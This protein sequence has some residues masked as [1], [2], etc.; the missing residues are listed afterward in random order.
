MSNFHHDKFINSSICIHFWDNHEVKFKLLGKESVNYYSILRKNANDY[1]WNTSNT[2]SMPS[3]SSKT[4]TALRWHFQSR[5]ISFFTKNILAMTLTDTYM[6]SFLEE[7]IYLSRISN[8][9]LTLS[10]S[11]FLNK[12]DHSFLLPNTGCTQRVE[13]NYPGVETINFEFINW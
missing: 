1:I 11:R 5:W 9:K 7:D 2:V 6:Y 8:K 10:E 4:A 12:K 3:K 13:W